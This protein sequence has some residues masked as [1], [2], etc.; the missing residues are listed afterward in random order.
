MRMDHCRCM[1]QGRYCCSLEKQHWMQR[2]N[3]VLPVIKL[4]F[5]LEDLQVTAAQ[6][7]S[8]PTECV[9]YVDVIRENWMKST[10]MRQHKGLR[11]LT[12][13]LA[14]HQVVISNAL[15]KDFQRFVEQE[16]AAFN[17]HDGW[18]VLFA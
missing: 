4:F 16:L 14:T 10:P 15:D 9:S 18:P 1:E 6:V 17:D 7:D 12:G 5:N 3:A 8:I 11:Q 13:G 2:A